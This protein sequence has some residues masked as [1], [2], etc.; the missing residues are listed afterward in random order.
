[1]PAG[2][3]RKP[4]PWGGRWHGEA[5]TDEGGTPQMRRSPFH[6]ISLARAA[7][8]TSQLP[9][10]G[11]AYARR[12]IKTMAAPL[13]LYRSKRANKIPRDAMFSQTGEVFNRRAALPALN[14]FGTAAVIRISPAIQCSRAPVRNLRFRQRVR[15]SI[16]GRHSL[17]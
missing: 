5:V 14:A 3:F 16:A 8:F 4:S 15:C 6:L 10:K 12:R 17:S 11:E 13:K 7:H 2:G 1:M 9:L